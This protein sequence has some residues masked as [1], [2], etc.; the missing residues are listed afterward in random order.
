MR[1]YHYSNE[2]L[3]RLEPVVGASRHDGEDAAAVGQPVVWLAD[4]T[5]MQSRNDEISAYQHEVEV[6]P[7][8][9][10][11]QEDNKF[12]D[13]TR[14]FNEVFGK[15]DRPALSLRWFF[16]KGALPVAARSVW[17][18]SSYVADPTFG[19]GADE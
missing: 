10:L 11:L 13:L 3:S 18:G 7:S 8:D 14:Q 6:N 19:G 12:A 15:P 5:M 16:Y 17:N 4:S 1:F 2:P 9:P